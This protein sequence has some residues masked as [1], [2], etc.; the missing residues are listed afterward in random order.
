MTTTM[1]KQQQ[2]Q[3]QQQQQQQK[4]GGGKRV[5]EE[6]HKWKTIGDGQFRVR[7]VFFKC[8]APLDLYIFADV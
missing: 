3:E 4:G 5:E 7:F 8:N 2:Q 6:V 1:M